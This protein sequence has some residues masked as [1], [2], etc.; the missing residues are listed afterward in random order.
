MSELLH[1]ISSR[2][3]SLAE[4]KGALLRGDFTLSSGIKSKYY[5]DGR[6]LTLD[7]EGAMLSGKAFNRLLRGTN[8]VAVGGPT[9]A[10]DPIVTAV[11]LIS[12]MEGRPISGFIVRKESKEHGTQNLIEGPLLRKSRVAIVDDTCTTGGSLLA[13]I[14]AVEGMDCT[15]EK[16]CVILDRDGHGRDLFARKGYS[17]E[18]I[19]ETTTDGE[20]KIVAPNT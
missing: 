14:S 4:E 10:A 19:L 17:F 16:V 2:I 15:V 8:V 7:P 3:L 18:A 12:Y 9:L 20:I 11:S 13:A 1:D 6:L 5:F